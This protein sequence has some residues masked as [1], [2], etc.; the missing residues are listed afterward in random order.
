LLR[1]I[2][3]TGDM[4]NFL[5]PK[6]AAAYFSYKPVLKKVFFGGAS[7]GIWNNFRNK[8]PAVLL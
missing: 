1:K 8:I 3:Q 2:G 7:R 5:S 4:K 6:N